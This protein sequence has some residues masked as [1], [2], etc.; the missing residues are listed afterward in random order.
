MAKTAIGLFTDSATADKVVAH[1]LESGFSRDE[2]RLVRRSD[3]EGTP[4]PETDILKIGGLPQEHAGRYWEAVRGGRV[5]VAVH[6]GRRYGGSGSR[7]H[8][9]GWRDNV[10][11]RTAKPVGSSGAR[12]ASSANP[13]FYPQ[14]PAAQLFEVS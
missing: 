1:L 10:D 6:F 13:G 8:G 3:F 7:H 14:R 2:V 11:E 12:A 4:G 5:L 9:P